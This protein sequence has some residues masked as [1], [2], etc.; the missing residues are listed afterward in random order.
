MNDALRPVHEPD[1][2][3]IDLDSLYNK[4]FILAMS[5]APQLQSRLTKGITVQRSQRKQRGPGNL[6]RVRVTWDN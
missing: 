4:R 1:L 6:I 3:T 5:P 2:V